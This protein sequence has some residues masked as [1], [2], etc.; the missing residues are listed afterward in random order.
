MS[1]L[2]LVGISRSGLGIAILLIGRPGRF[3]TRKR[4][5]VGV[6]LGARVHSRKSPTGGMAKLIGAL[7]VF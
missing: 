5:G 7:L 3:L 2:E 6:A 1:V 4:I